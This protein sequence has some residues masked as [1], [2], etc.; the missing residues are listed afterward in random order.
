MQAVT[1]RA[2]RAE[3]GRP[4]VVQ[5]A[6]RG[7]RALLERGA[8]LLVGRLGAAARRLPC[9]RRG[10]PHGIAHQLAVRAA[11]GLR[12]PQRLHPQRQLRIRDVAQPSQHELRFATGL[13]RRDDRLANRLDQRLGLLR[14]RECLRDACGLPQGLVRADRER[15]HE[16]DVGDRE[17]VV[18]RER[19]RGEQSIRVRPRRVLALEHRQPGITGRERGPDDRHERRR[20]RVLVRHPREERVDRRV[21]ERPVVVHPELIPGQRQRELVRDLVVVGER[22]RRLLAD[23][24]ARRAVRRHLRDRFLLVEAEQ[25]GIRVGDVE[26]E[27]IGDAR[28]CARAPRMHAIEQ[29]LRRRLVQRRPEDRQVERIVGAILIDVRQ[30]ER[31]VAVELRLGHRDGKRRPKSAVSVVA[32]ANNRFSIDARSSGVSAARYAL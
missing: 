26:R 1:E 8:D 13:R 19:A 16:A 24:L 9:S 25:R 14:C 15:L 11:L 12:E 28:R 6:G 20:E 32:Y 5:R 30:I 4:A 3:L 10:E 21:A 23:E 18:D 17:R 31:V 22:R 27:Q 7:V 29:L 2:R